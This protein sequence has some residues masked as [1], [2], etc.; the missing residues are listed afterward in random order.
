MKG[1]NMKR[2]IVLG[3]PLLLDA[4]LAAATYDV[5]TFGAK[6]DGV[7]FDTVAI[8]QA[9][10]RAFTDGGGTVVV[11]KGEWRI[12]ALRLRSRV[13][14]HLEA[15]ATILGSR[16]PDDYFI[17]DDDKVEPVPREWITHEAW[18]LE[19]SCSLDNFTRYPAS[20]WNNG[21]EQKG[22]VRQDKL[23]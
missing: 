12:K 10:D 9:I 16:D 19:Q 23:G 20:R 17:L 15:G 1:E 5:R 2:M 18:T 11:G 3:L 13:T 8:Q 6:G 22:Q 7:S 21:L 4:G 14:L